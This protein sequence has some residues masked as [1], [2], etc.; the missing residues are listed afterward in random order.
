MV[1][2]SVAGFKVENFTKGGA[3]T[4]FTTQ[5]LHL[6]LNEKE[7]R[8]LRNTAQF[9]HVFLRAHHQR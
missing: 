7:S 5:E 4:V 1:S 9:N 8:I 3:K 2:R 6:H